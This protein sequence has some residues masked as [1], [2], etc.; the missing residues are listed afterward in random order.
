MSNRSRPTNGARA[1]ALASRNDSASTAVAVSVRAAGAGGGRGGGRRRVVVE[2]HAVR[3]R[4][5]VAVRWSAGSNRRAA[6]AG[7]ERRSGAATP[8]DRRA[9]RRPTPARSARWPR[10]RLAWL[11]SSASSSRDAVGRSAT[12]SAVRAAHVSRLVAASPTGAPHDLQSCRPIARPTDDRRGYTLGARDHVLGD[13]LR[14]RTGRRPRVDTRSRSG[15][16]PRTPIGTSTSA[17]A[18]PCRPGRLRRGSHGA[19]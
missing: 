8:S 14:E 7:V 3:Q 5:D 9:A 18:G 10:P 2:Q 16:P 13:V 12:G 4:E 11:A 6:P 17:T 19:S 1:L 15:R